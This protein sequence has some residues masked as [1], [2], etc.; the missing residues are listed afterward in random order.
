MCLSVERQLTQIGWLH[1]IIPTQSKFMAAHDYAFMLGPVRYVKWYVQGR[2]HV[3]RVGG[4]IPCSRVLLP[5]YRKKLDR[6]TQFGA[7]GYII[8]L[9]SSKSYVKS[10]GPGPPD[11][12]WLRPW[13]RYFVWRD[14]LTRKC[15]SV[16]DCVPVWSRCWTL[17]TIWMTTLVLLYASKNHQLAI[18]T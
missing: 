9:C 11:P 12:Q 2:N 6:S 8:T 16:D 18:R 13:I 5:F 7:V 10:S 3:F 4:P 14:V 1:V 15:Q 17:I